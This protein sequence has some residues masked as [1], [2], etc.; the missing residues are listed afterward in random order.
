MILSLLKER[1]PDETRIALTP[2]VVKKLTSFGHH[3]IL[4]KNAGI[5]AYFTDEEYVQNGAEIRD[6]PEEIIKEADVLVQ[7]LPPESPYLKLL[8]KKQL[9]IADFSSVNVESL[10]CAAG[11]LQLEKV[12]RTSVAQSI[13][14]LSSEHTIRGYA[15]AVF[16]VSKLPKTSGVL[17]TAAATLKASTALVIGA[18]VTGLQAATVLHRLGINVTLS[19]INPSAEE[20]ALS[21][22]AKFNLNI[23]DISQ[24]DILISAVGNGNKSPKIL[25]EEKMQELKKSAVIIDTTAN[26]LAKTNSPLFYRNLYWERQTPISASELWAGNIFNLL[27]LISSPQSIPEYVIPLFYPHPPHYKG[28]S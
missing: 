16:A 3:V 26:N 7:I 11:L 19:D 23:G 25:S 27:Q 6:N 14:V 28:K 2:Q 10:P 4:E 21:V 15:A 5:K 22:G 8:R 9:L 18:S 20:L 1:D 17:M 12:P 13:D 24:T